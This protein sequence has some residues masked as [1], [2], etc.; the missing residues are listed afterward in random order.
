MIQTCNTE[1]I[2]L[3]I[4]DDIEAILL[5]IP[6]H[7]EAI[8]LII[9]GHIDSTLRQ[10]LCLRPAFSVCAWSPLL[11]KQLVTCKSMIWEYDD[12]SGWDSDWDWSLAGVR[13]RAPYSAD[14]NVSAM[15]CSRTVQ[16]QLIAKSFDR[17]NPH[18]RI[19]IQVTGRKLMRKRI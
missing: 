9:P 10:L 7:I 17:H 11:P 16:L 1:A 18:W 13:Y 4:H 19:K 2:L 14:N 8:L 5:I 12:I 3:T 6:D 15:H